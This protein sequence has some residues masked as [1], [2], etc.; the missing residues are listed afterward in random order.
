[1]ST[2]CFHHENGFWEEVCF[3]PYCSFKF[4]CES[5]NSDSLLRQF[6]E[7]YHGFEFGKSSFTEAMKRAKT[8]AGEG[9]GLDLV[10]TWSI[11]HCR[12]HE[13]RWPELLEMR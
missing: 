4:L 8:G 12:G 5:F 2:F 13:N 6:V 1:M 9:D 10:A 11:K 7:L 3:S